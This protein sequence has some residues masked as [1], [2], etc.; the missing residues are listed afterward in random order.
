[1]QSTNE[2]IKK[3]IKN[4]YEADRASRFSAQDRDKIYDLIDDLTLKTCDRIKLTPICR[5]ACF[6]PASEIYICKC[7]GR[8]PC[9]NIIQ[10]MYEETM[11][12]AERK[13]MQKG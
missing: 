6:L 2:K 5:Y 8:K 4:I 11:K 10:D 9:I 13:R 1:M 7:D 3:A 12:K